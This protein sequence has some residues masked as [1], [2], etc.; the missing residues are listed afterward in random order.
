MVWFSVK[1]DKSDDLRLP[2]TS[3][4]LS[5]N[6]DSLVV[7]DIIREVELPVLPD[8]EVYKSLIDALIERGYTEAKWDDPKAEDVFYVFPYDWRRDN[9]ETAR[10]LIQKMADAKAALKRPDLKFDII[11]HSMGGLVARYAAMYGSSDLPKG[12]LRPT[13]TWAGAMHINKLLIFGTPNQGSF[14]T[15]ETMLKGY[16]IVAGRNLPFVDDLRPEDVLTIP[17]IFQL[18]PHG[19]STR[20]L[21]ADLRPMK[22]NIYRVDTWLKYGWGPIT[23]PKFLSKLKDANR[24]ARLNPEIKPAKLEKEPST[25][26]RLIAETSYRQVYSYMAAALDRARRFHDALDATSGR[27][28]VPIY[29]Y[30]GDCAPTLDAVVIIPDEKKGRWVTLFEAKDIKTRAGKLWK[31]DDVKALM[32]APGDGRVTK[33]SLLAGTGTVA[34]AAVSKVRSTFSLTSSFFACGS[35]TKLFLE[36][37]IQDSFLSALLVESKIQP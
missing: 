18:L 29:A 2:M 32:F 25:D 24:L 16:P 13:P 14:D 12:N 5:Q 10:L 37:P 3:P 23:D 15:L 36:K 7:K 4:V 22:I 34:A 26:D 35:H 11:A 9:V 6:K 27:S 21:D 1:R 20:F 28:P 17:S 8:V 31:K 19:G 33:S 30:G